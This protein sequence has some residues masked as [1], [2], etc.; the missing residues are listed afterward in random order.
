MKVLFNLASCL[1]SLAGGKNVNV[2]VSERTA[3]IAMLW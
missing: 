3:Y 1:S 2:F